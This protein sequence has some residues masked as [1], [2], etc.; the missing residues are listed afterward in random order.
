MDEFANITDEQLDQMIT[1]LERSIDESKAEA[2]QRDSE[3]GQLTVAEDYM[4]DD[5]G[6]RL[7]VLKIQYQRRTV[8]AA[9]YR[10]RHTVAPGEPMD[11]SDIDP[12]PDSE[13][14]G[15]SADQ[16]SGGGSEAPTG[17]RRGRWY[18]IICHRS[19]LVLVFRTEFPVPS[20][21]DF[22]HC[23]FNGGLDN[24]SDKFPQLGAGVFRDLDPGGA[25]GS[26]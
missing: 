7:R 1:R 26:L 6:K 4:L 9:L 12:P 21:L 16:G 14:W 8:L 3:G 22:F 17:A 5:M 2:R 10:K 23:R 15:G 20:F 11:D 24:Q 25:E 18:S 19:L 13:A